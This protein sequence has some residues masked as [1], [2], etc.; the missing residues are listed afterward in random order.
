MP[1][2][3]DLVQKGDPVHVRHSMVGQNHIIGRTFGQ[4]F[5]SFGPG[6][7]QRDVDPARRKLAFQNGAV[8]ELVIHRQHPAH[9]HRH[10]HGHRIFGHRQRH[11]EPEGGP[12]AQR[13]V[14]PDRPP[15]VFDQP[16]CDRKAKAG[17]FKLA[18]SFI[19]D[20][21]E[22]TEHM[23][24]VL[25]RDADAGV[26]HRDM[27]GL[28]AILRLD[29]D[30]AGQDVAGFSELDRVADEVG[31]HLPQPPRIADETGGQ[32][33]VEVDHQ[34]DALFPRA[35]LQKHRH[36]MDRAFQIKGFGPQGQ[37]FRLDLGVVQNVVDDDQKRL[38]RRPDRLGK[39]TLFFRK[40]GVAQQLRHPH[41]PVHRGADLVAHV[42]KE[43]RL[44]AVRGFGRLAGGLKLRFVFLQLRH[45]DPQANAAAIRGR[46]VDGPDPAAIRQLL[47]RGARA[48]AVPLQ[49]AFQPVFLAPDGIGVLAKR[50]TKAQDIL[51]PGAGLHGGGRS[52]ID[53]A[54][55]LVAGQEP[56]FAVIQHE[57][58]G[59]RLDRG[60]YA[61]LFGDIQRKAHQIAIPRTM[62]LKLDP[63]A[64]AKPE[65]FGRDR[66]SLH[67]GQHA[68]HEVL[69]RLGAKVQRGRG[70]DQRQ[71]VGVGQAGGNGL[72]V[73][74]RKPGPVRRD[75][76]Q[77]AVKHGKPV[78]DGVHRI[79]QPAFGHHRC[80]VG[81][82]KI[83]HKAVILVLERLCLAQGRTHD[84]TLFHDLVRQRARMDR[85]LFIGGEQLAAFLFQKPLC[86]QPRAP[87]PDQT[88]RKIHHFPAKSTL[89]PERR[90]PAARPV[91]VPTLAQQSEPKFN[92]RPDASGLSLLA[93]PA[94]PMRQFRHSKTEGI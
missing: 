6:P 70:G 64:I 20:L 25:R 42:G 93:S 14:N 87:F 45:V 86:R 34:V 58:I 69:S 48:F 27:Q 83:G 78:A 15:H 32:E 22:L 9:C 3:A 51:E 94:R 82:V 39:Q 11:A 52:G 79:P 56:F 37:P 54:V 17:A 8:D 73:E 75:Q 77:P 72:A 89:L 36:L 29:P 19:L 84:L 90:R 1:G 7:A 2:G 76:A 66:V 33:H 44:G 18:V 49:P 50:Q 26:F 12:F 55:A 85:Q 92:P 47:F 40:A 61:H 21:I 53:V 43:G 71:H 31:Q 38:T 35:G 63:G 59:D 67:P 74:R 65:C 24:K 28:V 91:F 30:H 57:T 46:V 5:Q 60:P 88:F 62:I 68:R 13:A 80:R 4:P 16:P 10:L 23:V 81:A 41:N